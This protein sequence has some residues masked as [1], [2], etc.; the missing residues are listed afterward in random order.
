MSV[1]VQ[2]DSHVKNDFCRLLTSWVAYLLVCG[3]SLCQAGLSE[4]FRPRSLHLLCVLSILRHNSGRH[5]TRLEK[6]NSFAE[7]KS[8]KIELPHFQMH[9][10]KVIKVVLWMQLFAFHVYRILRGLLLP[11][12]ETRLVRPRSGVFLCSKKRVHRFKVCALRAL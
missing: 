3:L 4:V 9:Y 8:C 11:L 12:V 7:V 1:L 10:A 5:L 2:T 6:L